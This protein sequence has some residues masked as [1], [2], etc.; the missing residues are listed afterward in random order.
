[1]TT[2]HPAILKRIVWLSA[3]LSVILTATIYLGMS[4]GSTGVDLG[5]VGRSL[6]GYMGPDQTLNTIIWEIRLPRALLAAIIGATLSLGGLVFQAILRNPLAEPYI[7]GISGGAAIGAITGILLGLSRFPGV[8]LTSFAGS[9]VTLLVLMLISAGGSM[10]QKDR[11]LLSGVM[12][13]A[14][15]GAVIMF[16]ISV[17]QDSRLHNI[18]FWMMGDLSLADM[19]QVTILLIT[20]VPCFILIFYLS[21]AMNV[22]LLGHE[23]AQ[24]MGFDIRIIVAILLIVTSLMVSATVSHCG[25]VGFVGL[26]IPHLF[27]LLLG[28]DHRLLVPSC[29]LGGGAYMVL[30]DILART[31]PS[32]GEMPAGVVTA[33][34]GAPIFIY[35]LKRADR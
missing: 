3:L 19:H 35:L 5:A 6:L 31:L 18:I 26:V 4:I 11:L 34:I 21:H 20:V 10:V 24:S 2:G 29:L 17:T 16:L 33:L 8:S 30:C 14:F 9:M 22:L 25:L 7:L 28:A 23:M 12:V 1:M 27:R 15:C 13:N 32:H